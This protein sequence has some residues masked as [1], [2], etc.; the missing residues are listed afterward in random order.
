MGLKFADS[1]SAGE[2]IRVTS[3]AETLIKNAATAL[4][5]SDQM[6]I[7]T[8]CN[9]VNTNAPTEAGNFLDVYKGQHQP[10][11]VFDKTEH[12]TM[13]VKIKKPSGVE[14]AHSLYGGS[15]HLY[16]KI[17]DPTTIK[18]PKYTLVPCQITYT[19]LDEKIKSFDI[20]DAAVIDSDY[21]PSKK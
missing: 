7:I 11:G 18:D 16:I 8:W 3:T 5:G 20:A 12:L 14:T 21:V 9:A 1:Y 2:H 19:D 4:A 6:E 15:F 10:K 17:I 13:R